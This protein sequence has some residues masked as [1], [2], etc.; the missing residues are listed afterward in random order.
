MRRDLVAGVAI[1]LILAGEVMPEK[2][3]PYWLAPDHC[4]TEN[5]EGTTGNFSRAQRFDSSAATSTASTG[6]LDLLPALAFGG[7]SWNA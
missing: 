4:H 3:G 6:A 1:G 2:H 7:V 5:P